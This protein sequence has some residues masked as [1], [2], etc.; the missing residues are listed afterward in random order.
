MDDWDGE[1][2]CD[3]FWVCPLHEPDYIKYAATTC[4]HCRKETDDMM[5]VS[6]ANFIFNYCPSCVAELARLADGDSIV[7]PK[8]GEDN[9]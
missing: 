7:V 5:Y 4:E 3:G 9:E 6:I 8:E 2:Y 1:C